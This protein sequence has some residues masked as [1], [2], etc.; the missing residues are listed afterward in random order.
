L[1]PTIVKEHPVD[2]SS[3]Y[4]L[5]S[6][7]ETLTI[8]FAEVVVLQTKSLF[9][10]LVEDWQ[11]HIEVLQATL[12]VLDA[13]VD[14]RRLFFNLF[15]VLFNVSLLQPFLIL[16]VVFESVCH[17]VQCVLVI[18]VRILVYTWL[19][20][21]SLV[22][23]KLCILR[24]RRIILQEMPVAFHFLDFFLLNQSLVFFDF[25]SDCR[26]KV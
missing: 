18:L 11:S 4:E 6:I 22:N 8:S 10:D 2:Y 15:E 13:W 26:S 5:A 14:I 20:A 17:V 24:C 16:D 7:S 9:V 12:H 21:D 23:I 25:H 1:D 19:V 3:V